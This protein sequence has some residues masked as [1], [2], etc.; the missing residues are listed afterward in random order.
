VV[1]ITN[2]RDQDNADLRPAISLKG[3]W[4]RAKHQAT[5]YVINT[6]QQQYFS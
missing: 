2:L 1:L 3:N 4:R 6:Q 5:G